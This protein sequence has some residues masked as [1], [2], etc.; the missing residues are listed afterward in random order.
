[1]E[2]IENLEIGD[3]IDWK[4]GLITREIL[5]VDKDKYVISDLSCGWYEAVVNRETLDKV[6]NGEISLRELKWK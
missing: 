2:K 3:S 1:M 6:V 5:R 4:F